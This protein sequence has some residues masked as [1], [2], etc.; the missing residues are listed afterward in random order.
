MLW[1]SRSAVRALQLSHET[2]CSLAR[3][4]KSTKCINRR[5]LEVGQVDT[6]SK[7]VMMDMKL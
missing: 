2:A 4:V 3:V 5:I 6:L 1:I 7:L